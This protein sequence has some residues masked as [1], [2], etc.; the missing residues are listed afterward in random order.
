MS[1]NRIFS[2]LLLLVLVIWISSVKLLPSPAIEAASP[3]EKSEFEQIN[4]PLAPPMNNFLEIWVGDGVDNRVPAVAYNS[5]HDEFLVVWENDRGVTR[6]IYARRVAS[7]GDILSWFTV[8]S[9][10]GH[11]NYLPDVTYN[12]VQDEYLVVYTYQVTASDYD[13]WARRVKWDGSWMSPETPVN[14]DAAKQWYPAVAYNSQSNEY[15]VVYENDWGGLRDIA[16]QRVAA[17]GTLLSWRNIASGPG[18]TRRLPDVAYN[19]IRNEY[20]IAYTYDFPTDGDIRGKITSANMAMLSAEIEIVDNT[21]HQDDVALA[22]GPNEYLAI[23]EDGPNPGY[24]TVY[25]RRLSA[26]GALQPY[27]P[28]ANHSGEACVEP[29]VAYSHVYG[30]MTSWRHIPAMGS[31][32]VYGRFVKAGHNVPAD[33]EFPI[34]TSFNQQK[35]P[36]LACS[37]S[38]TCLLAEEDNYS[39]TGP[40]D[41]EI[42]GRFIIPYRLHLPFIRK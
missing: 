3:Y 7:S 13:I 4:L 22:A 15:L 35:S 9:D 11:W 36:A 6:D 24:R 34:D 14:Q 30:Y 39:P 27:I 25:G 2:I 10:A 40:I 33:V 19:E 5:R 23:W 21:H 17:N 31:W 32:D 26:T 29:A 1:K 28:I 42:R 20:L 41:Y 38:G 18:T 8:A 16:A 37:P 12:P